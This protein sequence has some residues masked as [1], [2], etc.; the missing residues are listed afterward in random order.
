MI[1]DQPDGTNIPDLWKMSGIIKLCPKEIQN[2]VDL[3]WGEI[4][5][6]YRVLK[7]R[8]IGWANTKAEKQE[9]QCR[10]K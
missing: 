1:R 8:V 9:E 7:H 10:W 6:E 2:M 5:A 3:R 4:G